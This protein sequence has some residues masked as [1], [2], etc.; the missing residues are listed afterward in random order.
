MCVVNDLRTMSGFRKASLML[1]V[2]AV[3]FAPENLVE[4]NDGTFVP[5]G[6]YDNRLKVSHIKLVTFNSYHA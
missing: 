4:I 6:P 3:C 1:N 5:F 2:D